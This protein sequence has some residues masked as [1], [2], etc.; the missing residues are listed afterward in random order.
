MAIS[1]QVYGTVR[2]AV[3]L[4][5]HSQ[6]TAPGGS[7]TI[8]KH[9]QMML[10]QRLGLG[11]SILGANLRSPAL[12]Y[13]V[14]FVATYRCNFRCE[15]CNIWQKKSVNEMTA[16]EVALFF[17]RW[18]QFRWVHLTGGELFMRRDLDDLVAAIQRSCRSLF[19]LNFPTTGWFG[20]K[21]VQLV[22]RTLARGVGRLMVTIS[23][24]GPK[25]LHEE[26]RGLPGSFDRAIETFR[27][28][29]G[30]RRSNF[31]AVVGMTLLTKNADS[32]E[33]TIESVRNVIPDFNRTELHLNIGHESGHYFDNLGRA[34]P[35]DQSRVARAIADHRQR[36]GTGLHPVH[37]LENRYQALV[38][39]YYRTGRSPLPCSALSTSCFID[40]YWN[41]FPCSIWDE[42]VG[43]LR[44][45][46]FDLGALWHS[47]KRIDLRQN[48]MEEQCPHCWTP[49]EAYPTLLANLTRA[50]AARGGTREIPAP[51]TVSPL[52]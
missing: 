29:R 7:V 16:D 1:D 49:C 42:K 5:S 50:V 4:L 36:N 28:L 18:P 30:I 13:K 20:D 35:V 47:Q 51:A 44:E 43:N 23:L 12:P 38:P 6:L 31:Q 14:T 34:V 46:A 11:A 15:M 27:R 9:S 32:V 25:A 33:A 22:E 3:K 39:A 48:V 24:D 52:P 37:F 21:T 2:Q 19:L 41:L 40:A 8:F 45:S 10:T 26:M 17:E